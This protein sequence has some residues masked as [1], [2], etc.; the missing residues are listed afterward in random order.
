[1]TAVDDIIPTFIPNWW[2]A[3]SPRGRLGSDLLL[4]VGESVFVLVQRLLIRLETQSQRE[5]GVPA[6]ETETKP[7]RNTF[8]EA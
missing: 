4:D 7:N 6:P 2:I 3:F 8:P 5:N 1:M